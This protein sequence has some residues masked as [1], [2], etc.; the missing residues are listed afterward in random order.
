MKTRWSQRRALLFSA[1]DSRVGQ[2]MARASAPHSRFPFSIPFGIRPAPILVSL[3]ICALL[4]TGLRMSILR[5]R[6]QLAAA[7]REETAML[8]RE[9]QAT[10]ALREVRDPQRL[11]QLAREYG[12]VRPERVLL[13]PDAQ[14][15]EHEQLPD[16]KQAGGPTTA[17]EEASRP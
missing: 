9:R 12:M 8:E 10:L 11:H 2:D 13:L 14:R 1:A 6:Y 15:P 5:T 4:L 16:A 7:L 3:I 17:P